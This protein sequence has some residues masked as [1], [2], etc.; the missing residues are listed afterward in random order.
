MTTKR[1]IAISYINSLRHAN[2]QALILLMNTYWANAAFDNE[3][4]DRRKV[5]ELSRKIK[6]N[7]TSILKVC[8]D[9]AMC[10]SWE[11]VNLKRHHSNGSNMPSPKRRRA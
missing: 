4:L 1:D 2:C 6:D 11:D 3:S 5:V 8:H 7:A 10:V 9:L